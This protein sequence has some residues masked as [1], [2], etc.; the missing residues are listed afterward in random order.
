MMYMMYARRS[1]SV[2]TMLCVL[3]MA[4]EAQEAFDPGVMVGE[5]APSF[6]L[7]DQDGR[8]HGFD[9]LK[10]DNG[11]AILFFRSA[12]WC[13][14]C[15][16]ALAQLEDARSGYESR[17]LKVVGISYDSID[18]LK[19][20]EQRVGIGYPMLSDSGSR[21]I[22][23]YGILNTDVPADN[24]Q[25][26]IPHPGMFILDAN[27]RV[28]SKYFEQNF[29]ERFT[30]ATILTREYGDAGGKETEIR[31]EHFTMTTRLS[32]DAVARGNRVSMMLAI[33]LPDRMHLYAP[34]VEGYRSVA[35]N[36]DSHPAVTLAPTVF[37]ES[38]VLYLEAIDESVSVYHDTI[39]L[40]RDF[41]LGQTNADQIVLTGSL[42]YQACNDE[43]C[44]LPAEV[45]V[46]FTLNVG[47]LDT[48]RATGN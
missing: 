43:I 1:L 40:T 44:F 37:P 14:F 46:R 20:F 6:R 16:T 29:R 4:A 41:I 42:T 32:Q 48:V 10:G 2:G 28:V 9:S 12:D 8:L 45:P 33:D 30:P 26:G 36:I 21:I 39:R 11:L 18:I 31:T 23:D 7:P 13:P 27:G 35:L 19:T 5:M 3:A 24:P 34:G 22:S 15:K 47:G 38:E 25:Y 17:G